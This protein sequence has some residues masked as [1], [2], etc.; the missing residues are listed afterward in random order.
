MRGPRAER[1]ERGAVAVELALCIPA[2][3]MIVFG[4]VM[5]A[6][7]VHARA[8]LSEAVGYAA[9]AESI[10][11][12]MRPG[13][14]DANT[15]RQIVT[16]RM[17]TTNECAQPVEVQART[18]VEFNIRRLEV[19]ATCRLQLGTVPFLPSVGITQVTAT[20]SMPLDVE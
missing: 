9:R 16:Q 18:V 17:T 20:A 3:V 14:L 8:R 5:L 1:A 15:V 19:N 4:G 7:A 13:G 2:L 12:A 11:A 10:A 6:R